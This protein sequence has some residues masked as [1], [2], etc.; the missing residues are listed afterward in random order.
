MPG[1]TPC[2]EVTLTPTFRLVRTVD[3]PVTARLSGRLPLVTKA[4]VAE[5]DV[6]TNNVRVLVLRPL[7]L[8]TINLGLVRIIPPMA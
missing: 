2:Y 6:G 3:T 8:L 7:I 1:M 4:R 5:S